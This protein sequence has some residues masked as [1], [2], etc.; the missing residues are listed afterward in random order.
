MPI[1]FG[2]GGGHKIRYSTVEYIFFFLNT[3]QLKELLFQPIYEVS[4][5]EFYR[6]RMQT[7]SQMVTGILLWQIHLSMV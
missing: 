2:R 7:A 4:E 6:E 1:C 3:V 5:I